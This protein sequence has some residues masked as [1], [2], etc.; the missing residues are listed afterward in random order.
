MSQRKK[1]Y[2]TYSRENYDRFL[3]EYNI[4]EDDLPFSKWKANLSTC[5]WMWIE[6]ALRTGMK[7]NLPF[8][9]GPLAVNKKMLKRFKEYTDSEGQ[10]KKV[11]NLRIDWKKTKE[12]GKRVYHTNEHTDGFNFKWM[13]FSE[14][15]R[16][17][18]ANL[19]V[20]NPGR[21]ASRAINKYLKKPGAD[22]KSL[23]MEW[24]KN[25]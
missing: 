18:L 17:Y 22:F 12:L 21:Y 8:G 11:I 1:E 19:Y 13:W 6:Y 5:N 2:R 4:K 3:K 23:Y 16:F 15:A 9:F 20:F 25:Y 24:Q 14:E 10:K 7:V